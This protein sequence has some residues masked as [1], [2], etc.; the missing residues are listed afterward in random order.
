MAQAFRIDARNTHDR[1]S[2][3]TCPCFVIAGAND[4]VFG[5]EASL[6]MA[7]GP[8]SQLPSFCS[9][10]STSPVKAGTKSAEGSSWMVP[11]STKSISA[12]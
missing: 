10:N 2:T 1:L 4:D 3:I 6:E 7:T 5:A 11:F 9:W 8:A 12:A